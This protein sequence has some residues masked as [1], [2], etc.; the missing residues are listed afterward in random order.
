MAALALE[1]DP[2]V[3]LV[4][5]DEDGVASASLGAA[6]VELGLT[7]LRVDRDDAIALERSIIGFLVNQRAESDRQAEDLQ[8]DL[9][10][11][12]LRGHGL[13]ALAAAIGAALGRGSPS[14]DR[15]ATGSPC[16]S[17]RTGRTRRPR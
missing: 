13:D 15:T 1:P 12:A 7:V 14:R 8:R 6:A 10:R 17:R 4:G 9:A 2:G 3:L 11:L 16:T 5:G